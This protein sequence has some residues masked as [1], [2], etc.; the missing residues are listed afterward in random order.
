MERTHAKA[1]KVPAWSRRDG[2]EP[3]LGD[4]AVVAGDEFERLTWDEMVQVSLRAPA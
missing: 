4:L 1:N 2:V 3:A